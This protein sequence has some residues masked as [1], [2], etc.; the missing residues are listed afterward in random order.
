MTTITKD[1]EF[2]LLQAPKKATEQFQM[3]EIAG[4]PA[5]TTSGN[6]YLILLINRTNTCFELIR[7]RN[8]GMP[9]SSWWPLPLICKTC[10]LASASDCFNAKAWR[11]LLVTNCNSGSFDIQIATKPDANGNMMGATYEGISPNCSYGGGVLT[12]E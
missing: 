6:D 12:I 7:T 5:F 2:E 4:A 8:P 10:S 9:W 1:N 3:T 11:Q